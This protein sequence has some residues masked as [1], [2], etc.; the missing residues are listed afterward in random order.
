M[1]ESENLLPGKQLPDEKL[2]VVARQYVAVLHQVGRDPNESFNA[3]DDCSDRDLQSQENKYEALPNRGVFGYPVRRGVHW[4]ASQPRQSSMKTHV[5]IL[6]FLPVVINVASPLAAEP[7]DRIALEFFEKRVRPLLVSRCVSCHGEKKQESGLRLDSRAAI[8]KGSDEGTVVVPGQPEKSSL[9]QA[10]RHVG[11]VKMPPKRKLDPA[12]INALVKWVQLGLPWPN[13]K[14]AGNSQASLSAS[15]WAFQPIR[16]PPIP[17]VRNASWSRT[18]VDHFVL[19][20]LERRGLQPSPEA[21]RRTLI[22]RAT[23]DLWGLPPTPADVASFENDPSPDAYL[24]LIDRLLASPRYGE[25]WGRHWLDVAR[26]ADNKGYVFFED[27][28]FPWAYTYRDYVIRSFNEDLAFDRFVIEQLAADRLDLRD[29]RRPLTAMGFLTLGGRFMNNTHNVIDDRIDV[30]TRGLLG[31]TVGCARCHDHKFDPLTQADY[32]ALYGVFRSS[33]DP[34]LPP[35]FGEPAS[36]ETYQKFDTEMKKRMQALDDFVEKKRNEVMKSARDRVGE[37]LMR[38][39]SRRNQPQTDNFMLLVPAGDLVPAVILRWEKYLD[40]FRD[41]HHRVW[42]PWLAFEALESTRFTEQAVDVL[43]RLQTSQG[44][45]TSINERLLARLKTKPLRSMQDVADA[46]ADVLGAIDKDWQSQLAAAKKSGQ[47]TPKSLSSATDEEL[48]LV[49][50]SKDVP[51]NIPRMLGWGFLSLLP[52][53][54]AQGVFKKLLKDVETWSMTGAGAP[55][56]AM[57]L[58]DV[59]VPFE[60]YVFLRGNPHRKGASVERRFPAVLGGKKHP[61]RNG[62]GRLELAKAIV[63]PENPLTARVF[64][65]R[66][67]I[68]HFGR[69]LVSTASDFGLRSNPPTHPA[70]L[71]YLASEFITNGWSVKHLHRQVM[72]SSI[73]RQRSDTRLEAAQVDPENQWLWRMNRRRLDFES[74][75]DSL[76]EIADGFDPVIGGPPTKIAG[77]GF[78]ARRTVYGFVDRMNMPGLYR[79]FDFPSPNS[80]SPARETTTIAPQA[81]FLMNNPFGREA[82]RRLATRSDVTARSNTAGRVDQIHRLLFARPASDLERRLASEFLGKASTVEDWTRYTHAL[83]MTNEF[84]FVD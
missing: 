17:T 84:L 58:N 65:N 39:Y 51:A 50:Y 28:N 18:P 8:L 47:V 26:Y 27:K 60:P 14:Q 53:R 73:Y 6:A 52:D 57:V 55:P 11:D 31:L 33:H 19:A 48:R 70:L 81:L 25:R 68:H 59:P 76:I 45:K 49:F 46:Y 15:H 78:I 34:L 5:L 71:D 13:S 54:P 38:V 1:A 9:I 21:H 72:L 20:E 24:R 82:A 32:Y 4:F 36:T 44:S 2:Y 16:M 41:R 37:Y 40:R 29:D 77:S 69:G 62:S 80:S 30:V 66:V 3:W 75:R 43:D 12:E 35:L 79:T 10:V 23:F 56:R 74:L 61:F 7:R 83:L 67:W 63:A 64:V 22:R 42:I